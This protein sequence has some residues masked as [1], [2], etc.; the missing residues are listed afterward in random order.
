MVFSPWKSDGVA[1][2]TTS[3]SSRPARYWK[4]AAALSE[5]PRAATSA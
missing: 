2:A 4:N 1:N 3:P 5:E